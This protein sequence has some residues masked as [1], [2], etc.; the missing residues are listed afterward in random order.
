MSLPNRRGRTM[1]IVTAVVFVAT[2][3]GRLIDVP[4]VAGRVKGDEATYVAMAFSL[5]KDGD[6][7][8]RAGRSRTIPGD[9]STGAGGHISQ[10]KLASEP[11]VPRR[12]AAGANRPNASRDDREP[13]VRQGIRVSADRGAICGDRRPR[14]DARAERPAPRGV[15]LVRR[16]ILSSARGQGHRRG[17]RRR[18]RHRV[19]RSCLRRVPHFRDFQ[20][21]GRPDWLFL[22]VVQA[23]QSPRRLRSWRPNS[24]RR[25]HAVPA[26]DRRR[27]RCVDRRGDLLEAR[28]SHRTAGARRPHPVAAAPFRGRRRGVPVDDRRFLSGERNR[29]RRV[30]LSRRRS[31]VVLRHVPVQ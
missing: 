28:H 30:E 9:L 3:A 31:P 26:V 4:R 2:L 24:D 27:R 29:D 1:A 16:A 11:R 21:H 15:R 7:E 5:A 8:V 13:L 18:I 10:A 20:L 19:G 17:V 6:L 25:R 14:R 22:L 23:R 12:M